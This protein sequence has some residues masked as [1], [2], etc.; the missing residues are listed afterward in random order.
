MEEPVVIKSG[1]ISV[2]SEVDAELE[3]LKREVSGR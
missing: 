1:A 2:G 3:A